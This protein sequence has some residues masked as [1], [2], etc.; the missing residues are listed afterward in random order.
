[1]K[2]GITDKD[3]TLYFDG[4]EVE[5]KYYLKETKAPA[6]YEIK[7]D[8]KVLKITKLFDRISKV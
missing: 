3:G 5:K 2:K 6:G 8:E 1:M 4:L 7:K